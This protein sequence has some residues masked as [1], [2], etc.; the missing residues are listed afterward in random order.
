LPGRKEQVPCEVHQQE[1]QG[2]EPGQEEKEGQNGLERTG[3]LPGAATPGT[4]TGEKHPDGQ[5][6]AHHQFISL[7]KGGDLPD[8]EHLDHRGEKSRAQN[9][10]YHMM[11]LGG[12]MP[13]F[14]LRAGRGAGRHGF[15]VFP[16]PE[17]VQVIGAVPQKMEHGHEGHGDTGV[18]M[19]GHQGI[20]EAP[21]QPVVHPDH[22]QESQETGNQ[23]GEE[24]DAVPEAAVKGFGQDSC[25]DEQKGEE[26]SCSRTQGNKDQV[27]RTLHH[28]FSNRVF[29]AGFSSLKTRVW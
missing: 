29:P 27:V 20:E 17:E 14:D 1:K 7:E 18:D 23:E 2:G 9:K 13:I 24:K 22:Q 28:G 3:G 5:G 21:F 12:G 19:P 26:V 11:I 10:G 15:Y 16:M 4:G 25:I 6:P 8:Q